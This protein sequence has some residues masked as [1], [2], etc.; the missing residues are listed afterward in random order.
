[1]VGKPKGKR[2][3]DEIDKLARIAAM[4]TNVDQNVGR[5]LGKLDQLGPTDNTIVIFLV[6]NG[7]NTLRY[8]GDKRGM[9]SHVQNKRRSESIVLTTCAVAALLAHSKCSRLT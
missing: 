1:M 8:V 3:T 2:L 9:K 4:I 5:L 6:D 7:P